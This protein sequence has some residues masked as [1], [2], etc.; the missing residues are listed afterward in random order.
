MGMGTSFAAQPKNP[1]GILGKKAPVATI[2]R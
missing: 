2:R 1:G